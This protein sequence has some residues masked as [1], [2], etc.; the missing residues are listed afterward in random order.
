MLSF[1]IVFIP[2]DAILIWHG[3]ILPAKHTKCGRQSRKNENSDKLSKLHSQFKHTRNGSIK[4]RQRK[5][6]TR[7]LA[8]N[9]HAN[10]NLHRKV[11]SLNDTKTRLILSQLFVGE[12]G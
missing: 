5:V 7:T 4:P 9:K 8:Y 11:Q 6:T 3:T 10:G 1:A 2:F 12:T